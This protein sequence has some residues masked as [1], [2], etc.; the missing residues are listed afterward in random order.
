[1]LAP[2]PP[3]AADAGTFG[4]PWTL[5]SLTAALRSSGVAVDLTRVE[6]T[7]EILKGLPGNA[8]VATGT[9]SGYWGSITVHQSIAQ[10]QQSWV[11]MYPGEADVRPRGYW[12]IPEVRSWSV[13]NAVLTIST[14]TSPRGSGVWLGDVLTRLKP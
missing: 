10:R 4:K 2:G 13:G 6:G 14:L 7:N 3:S 8:I 11:T 5:E 9:V 1:L 12:T